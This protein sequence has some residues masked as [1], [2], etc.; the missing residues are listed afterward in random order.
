[1][2]FKG[3]GH[4]EPEIREMLLNLGFTAPF[5]LPPEIRQGPRV[6]ALV[7][8]SAHLGKQQLY[9]RLWGCP[10]P[11]SGSRLTPHRSGEGHVP[12]WASARVH[13]AVEA[14]P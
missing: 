2:V 6:Q 5:L 12:T 7:P 14:L 13:A 1:M 4:S 9:P 10:L 11:D 8:S 3:W